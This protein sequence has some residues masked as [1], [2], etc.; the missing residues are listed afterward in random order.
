MRH[1]EIICKHHIIY[2]LIYFYFYCGLFSFFVFL[3]FLGL[4]PMAYGGSQARGSSDSFTWWTMVASGNRFPFNS[5]PFI[6]PASSPLTMYVGHN[7][8]ALTVG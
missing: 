2:L 8:Q 5:T 4:L 7:E 6:S 1:D 3:P